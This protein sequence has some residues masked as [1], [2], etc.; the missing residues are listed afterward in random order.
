T[1][2][3]CVLED[4]SLQRNIIIIKCGSHSTVVWN[5]WRQTAEKMG[6]LGEHGYLNMLCVETANAAEDAVVIEPGKEHHLWVQYEVQAIT[7][8]GE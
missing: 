1:A 6:D 4:R 3:D 2:T 8:A 7:R 5:P